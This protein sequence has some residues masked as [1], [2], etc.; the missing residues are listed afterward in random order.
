MRDFI[1]WM[2]RRELYG[3]AMAFAGLFNRIKIRGEIAF[4]IG[5]GTCSFTQHIKGGD[6]A[7]MLG[8]RHA[9]AGLF[10]RAAHHKD[11]AH[12]AHGGAHRL[13][14]KGLARAGN[15]AT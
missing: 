5:K 13:T 6:K 14:D 1:T 3:N 15:Q 9:R 12:H 7:F 11:F 8:P 2:E 4:P 10:N